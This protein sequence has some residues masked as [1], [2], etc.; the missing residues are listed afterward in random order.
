MEQVTLGD[1]LIVT[2]SAMAIVFAVLASL[3]FLLEM[4]HKIL[5]MK[6]EAA[7]DMVIPSTPTMEQRE[8]E[9]PL[10]EKKF[11]VAKLTALIVAHSD[12]PATKYEIVNVERVK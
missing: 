6:S 2:I 1:G 10:D 12:S 4:I 7:A 5:S 3:W 9:L 11:K 8:W